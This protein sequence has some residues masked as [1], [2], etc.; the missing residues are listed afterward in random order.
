ML[1]RLLICSGL[2]FLIAAADVIAAGPVRPNYFTHRQAKQA[3]RIAQD[4]CKPLVLHFLPETPFGRLQV[5]S[6]YDS[7]VGGV[8]RDVLQQAV[9]VI[10]PMPRYAGF[11]AQLG[12]IEEGGLRTISP[13]DLVAVDT[14]SVSTLQ[15]VLRCKPGFR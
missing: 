10:L 15:T 5:R 6:Y 13:F 11:A 4:E 12:I 3:Q 7:S 8:S 14:Q 9:V 1:R 2:G